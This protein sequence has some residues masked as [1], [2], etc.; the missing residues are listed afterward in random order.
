MRLNSKWLSLFVTCLALSDFHM[1]RASY[2]IY[3]SQRELHSY[4]IGTDSFGLIEG[5][6]LYLT[7]M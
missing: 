2:R 3:I 5:E 4:Y 6:S 1:C 7:Y